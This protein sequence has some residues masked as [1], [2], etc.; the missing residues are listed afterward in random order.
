MGGV[1]GPGR[2]WGALAA[3]LALGG[4]ALVGP[5]YIRP[6]AIVPAQYKEIKGWKIGEPRDGLNKGAWWQVFH[7][8]ELDALEAQVEISNQTLKADEANYR[9]AQALI[10]EARA[11]L[12]PTVTATGDAQR[13]NST[14]KPVTTL[15]LE[16]NAT[17]TIDVWGKIRRTIES[18]ASGAQASAADLA[19]AKLSAQAALAT[20]Y[21][22]LR[23]TDSLHDLLADAVSQYNRSL[24]ITKNQYGA[25]TSARSDVITAQAQVLAAQAQEINTGVARA[26]F[27]HAI[28]VLMG[29]PPAGLSIAHGALTHSV[30]PVPMSLPSTLLERRPDIAAAERTMQEQ[31]ALIG[32]AIAA[33]YPDVTLS[34]LFGVSGSPGVKSAAGSNPVWSI[35]LSIAQT[36]FNGGLTDAQVAAARATYEA[37]VATY[38]ETVLSAFQQVEDELVAIRVLGQEE[39]VQVEA[40]KAAEQAVQIALNEY[41]AGTQNFT[42]VVTAEATALSDEETLLTTREQRIEAAV[43]LIVALGGGWTEAKLLPQT[44]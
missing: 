1:R 17:W 44:E 10:A 11:D 27:E 38:R 6:A 41:R 29:R 2:G 12:F 24:D 43:A 39:S 30:P 7:D 13:I 35:G 19:N 9:E 32:V 15:S 5:D 42:T 18:Q 34:G 26:Q 23:E 36:L 21:Y 3:A 14:G 4:C 33:Y 16:G 31:N 8:R 37:S 40:V 22:Q 28:A 20:A 25:G